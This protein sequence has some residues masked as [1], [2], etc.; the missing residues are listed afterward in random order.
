MSTEYQSLDSV[1]KPVTLLLKGDSGTGKTYKAA[2]FP[3]P[4]FFNFDNNLSG[5]RKLPTEV[6]SKI[7]VKDPR[8][9]KN[10]KQVKDVEIWPNF[11]S[12]LEEVGA[13]SSVGTIVLDSLTTMAEVL[14]DKILKTSD[15]AARV[16]I[17]HW[18]DLWRYFKWLGE[19]LL[20]ATDLDK[21]VIWIAHEQM[22]EF[23]DAKGVSIRSPKYFLM[24]GGKAKEGLDLFF[25]DVWRA[26]T[27]KQTTMPYG[28]EYWIRSLPDEYHTAKTSLTLPPDFKWDDQKASIL[29]QLHEGLPGK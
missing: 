7:R 21:H 5:L 13:D 26:Y 3:D 28:V 24:L 1:L 20:C 15:P 29:K 25:T 6:R 4:V 22:K 17:Q 27:K 23:V 2:Q 11:V 9:D 14:M 16:E 18:G 8:L 10:G 12:Q 19:E